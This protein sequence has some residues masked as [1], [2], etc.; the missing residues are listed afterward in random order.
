MTDHLARTLWTYLNGLHS[1]VYWDPEPRE[2]YQRVGLRGGW[3]Q[4]FASRSAALGAVPIDVVTAVFYGFDPTLARRGLEGVWAD[5]TPE[6]VSEARL[7]GAD[8]ALTRRLD[9]AVQDG[10]VGAAADLARSAAE[11][12][13]PHGRPLFAAHLALG[14]PDSPHLALWHAATLYR[15]Y[16]GDGH[17]AV[18]M[19]EGIDP[20]ESLVLDAATGRTPADFLRTNRGWTDA[21]WEGATTALAERGFVNGDGSAT[22][23]G[24][25]LRA[26]V[27]RQTDRLS[28]QPWNAVGSA[29]VDRLCA[30][31][32]VLR[33]AGHF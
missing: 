28:E 11:A 20:C 27:E 9:P 13:D 3:R 21:D 17:V 18:L 23:A 16:R 1:I 6:R 7:T 30:A 26:H 32:Q 12:C 19:A 33:E 2:E 29:G 4:Y 25:D 31:L 22:T 8:R 24:L 15:E 10:C 14:W 5:T